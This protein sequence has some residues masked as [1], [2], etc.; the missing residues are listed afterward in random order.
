MAAYQEAQELHRRLT[1]AHPAVLKHRI[2]LA[3]ACINLGNLWIR[4]SQAALAVSAFDEAVKLFPEA[5]R[6][7]LDSEMRSLLDKAYAGRRGSRKSGRRDRH[8][9]RFREGN[10]V[11][12]AR[13][14]EICD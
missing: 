13:P 12:I 6:S 7:T 8:G 5:S 11:R 1:A 10:L 9:R 2:D 4:R 14:R 3:G